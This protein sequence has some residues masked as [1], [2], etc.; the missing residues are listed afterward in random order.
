M[1]RN[2]T[3]IKQ[4]EPN[5]MEQ[6]E[7]TNSNEI[8]NSLKNVLQHFNQEKIEAPAKSVDFILRFSKAYRTE[9]LSNG[10]NFEML[11]N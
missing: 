8:E 5:R 3:T 2:F 7:V 6:P 4:I 11:I 9:R 1:I 10:E